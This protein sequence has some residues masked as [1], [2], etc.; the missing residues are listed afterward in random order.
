M[1]REEEIATVAGMLSRSK[2]AEHGTQADDIDVERVAT[3]PSDCDERT[4]ISAR[5]QRYKLF[6]SV[7]QKVNMC[8]LVLFVA[9]FVWT[10][11]VNRADGYSGV[12]GYGW[13]RSRLINSTNEVIIKH[14]VFPLTGYSDNMT[15][16][17]VC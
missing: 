12:D 7:L 17:Q 9:F 14:A 2:N 16:I 1:R 11:S 15:M 10:I 4:F 6:L 13:N 3:S 5:K 8:F